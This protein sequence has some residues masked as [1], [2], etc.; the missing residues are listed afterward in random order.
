MAL[1][2]RVSC[3]SISHGIGQIIQVPSIQMNPGDKII[4]Y[5][6]VGQLDLSLTLRISC[7]QIGIKIMIKYNMN[8]LYRGGE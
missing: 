7:L 8:D 1:S 2:G 4:Y 3:I 6:Q 5:T